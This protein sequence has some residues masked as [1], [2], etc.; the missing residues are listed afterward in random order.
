VALQTRGS[1]RASRWRDG[2]R[3]VTALCG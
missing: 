1:R 2:R 3:P